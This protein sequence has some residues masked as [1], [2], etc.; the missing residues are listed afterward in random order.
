MTQTLQERLNF[1]EREIERQESLEHAEA[2][3]RAG[4][5]DPETVNPWHGAGQT[6]LSMCQERERIALA[7]EGERLNSALAKQREL[8]QALDRLSLE[9]QIADRA[10]RTR[11]EHASVQRYLAAGAICRQRGWAFSWERFRQFFESGR[12]RYGGLT[13]DGAFFLDSAQARDANVRFSLEFDRAPVML[14]LEAL[15]ASNRKLAE[16]N[17]VGE[18][19]RMLLR[20]HPE[21]QGVA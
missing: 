12:Q 9:R 17:A 3:F 5:P 11:A 18:Q 21:L 7:I 10:V 19:L 8:R 13:E 20:E 6:L 16:W 1:L 4:N 2:A 14:Y 15:D